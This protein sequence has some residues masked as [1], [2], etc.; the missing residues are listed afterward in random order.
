MK[1]IDVKLS[2]CDSSS[3][4]LVTAG[5]MVLDLEVGDKVSLQPTQHN[6]IIT[7]PQVADNTFTGMLLFPT[8]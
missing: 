5:S 7:S 1:G 3:S 6:K 8:V 4:H 2:M